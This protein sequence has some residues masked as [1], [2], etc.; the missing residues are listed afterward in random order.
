MF[1]FV[2]HPRI[3][4]VYVLGLLSTEIVAFGMQYQASSRNA[5]SGGGG[6][7][8]NQIVDSRGAHAL[9]M[10]KKEAEGRGNHELITTASSESATTVERMTCTVPNFRGHFPL[11][12]EIAA[13][14]FVM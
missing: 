11:V 6:Q 4:R 3:P 5:F 7:V 14:V 12:V 9:D 1:Q 2:N 13:N 10:G 8:E